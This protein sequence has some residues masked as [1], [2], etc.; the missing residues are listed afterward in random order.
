MHERCATG[1]VKEKKLSM[2]EGAGNRSLGRKSQCKQ[3]CGTSSAQHVE[4]Q[5]AVEILIFLLNVTHERLRRGK[6][7]S[8]SGVVKMEYLALHPR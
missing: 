6:K 3:A 8:M 1:R 7:P 5:L 2:C 4:S